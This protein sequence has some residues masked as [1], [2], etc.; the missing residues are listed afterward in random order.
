[1]SMQNKYM[2]I[3]LYLCKIENIAKTFFV[4][5]KCI[6]ST[7]FYLIISSEPLLYFG[8]DVICKSTYFLYIFFKFRITFSVL[9]SIISLFMYASC[10]F[11][12][13]HNFTC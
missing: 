11:L 8:T 4:Y 9:K 3:Y 1:M 7:L 5:I 6:L 2:S 10:I 13:S 12:E